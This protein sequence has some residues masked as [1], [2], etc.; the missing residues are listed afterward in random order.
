MLKRTKKRT[1]KKTKKNQNKIHKCAK[2]IKR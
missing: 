1:K 2:N